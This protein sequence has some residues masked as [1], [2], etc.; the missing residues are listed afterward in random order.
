MTPEEQVIGVLAGDALCRNCKKMHLPQHIV[1]RTQL[2]RASCCA[3]CAC[4]VEYGAICPICYNE[5]ASFSGVYRV[6]DEPC[7]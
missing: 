5:L 3:A 1:T 2:T 7:D 6:Q 4:L